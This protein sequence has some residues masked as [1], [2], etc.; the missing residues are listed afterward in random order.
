MLASPSYP[1]ASM[2]ALKPHC[3]CFEPVAKHYCCWNTSAAADVDNIVPADPPPFAAG[4]AASA[5]ACYQASSVVFV[6]ETVLEFVDPSALACWDVEVVAAEEAAEAF[7]EPSL[8]PFR[9]EH[10]RVYSNRDV[11]NYA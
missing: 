10:L 6:L 3:S 7:L 11:K 4:A 1:A 2:L 9:K 5:A 8:H